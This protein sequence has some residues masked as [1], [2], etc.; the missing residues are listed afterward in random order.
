MDLRVP[1]AA[2]VVVD[3]LLARE[4]TDVSVV[5]PFTWVV[6]SPSRPREEVRTVPDPE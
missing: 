1:G 3:H 5:Q 4:F 6:L 2:S